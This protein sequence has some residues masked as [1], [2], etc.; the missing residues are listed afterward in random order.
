MS[1]REDGNVRTEGGAGRGEPVQ[2]ASRDLETEFQSEKD[3]ENGDYVELTVEQ[4]DRCMETG[5]WPKWP[6]GSSL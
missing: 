5:E 6:D 3:F 1:G 4:L 2:Y